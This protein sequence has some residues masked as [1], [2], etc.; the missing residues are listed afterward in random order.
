[1]I[2]PVLLAAICLLLAACAEQQA[3][4]V[5]LPSAPPPG[6]PG[7][8]AGLSAAQ[9]RAAFGE[10]TFLRKDGK[11]ET[12]RYDGA[13]C[14][15]FFFLYPNEAGGENVRHV[16]TIPRGQQI[17]ADSVCLDTLMVRK[18]VPSS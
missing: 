4:R 10:P 15:A 11:I 18:S 12:W 6:E 8:V 17:A 13:S 5:S 9:I 16:E 14:K 3:A 2:R 1:M 7:N